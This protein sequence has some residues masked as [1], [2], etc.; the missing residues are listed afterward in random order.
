[1]PSP[2]PHD[3]DDEP[4]ELLAAMARGDRDAF[5]SLYDRYAP[6]VYAMALRVL[7]K[8]AEAEA[9]VSDV[10]LGLWENPQ[11][12]NPSRGPLRA[13]LLMAARSR[14]IDRLR[15]AAT[16]AE[17]T[18]AAGRGTAGE[19]VVRA[20]DERPES[21]LAETENRAQ[22]HAAVS[23]LDSKQRAPLELAFFEG[24]THAEIAQRLGEPLGTVKT[25]IRT[26]L[27]TLRSA[28]R[29]TAKDRDDM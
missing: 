18:E 24:L 11:R 23:N 16:R 26:A 29:P 8:E 6:R 7:R 10:F 28:L 22:L 3:P 13:Y 1:M 15:A 12:F 19:R 14:A 27:T 9:V 25:R 4:A 2:P 17:R 20:M 21:R 5:A